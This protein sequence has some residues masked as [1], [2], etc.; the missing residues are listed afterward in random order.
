MELKYR[1][2]IIY[3]LREYKNLL[4]SPEFISDTSGIFMHLKT[5]YQETRRSRSGIYHCFKSAG[6]P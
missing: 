5:S 6:I 3:A 2:I 4:H 1:I